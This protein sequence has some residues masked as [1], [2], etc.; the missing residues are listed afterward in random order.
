MGKTQSLF[1]GRSSILQRT[2]LDSDLPTLAAV[3]A[4]PS[5][6]AVFAAQTNHRSSVAE[7][8][9][10]KLRSKDI[11]KLA[12]ISG[13]RTSWAP[14]DDATQENASTS[15]GYPDSRRHSIVTQ[16]PPPSPANSKATLAPIPTRPRP[17]RS[18]SAPILQTVGSIPSYP[19]ELLPFLDGEHHTDELATQF[20]AGWPLLERWLIDVGGAEDGSFGRVSI[21]YR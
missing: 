13:S 16:A 8:I 14:R 12:A 18:P 7:Q 3:T 17:S 19:P 5:S 6:D 1:R 9:L 10:E 20:K 11:Q 21:I 4:T 2:P 15:R